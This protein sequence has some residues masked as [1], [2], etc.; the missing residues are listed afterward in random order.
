MK[1]S[2]MQLSVYTRDKIQTLYLTKQTTQQLSTLIAKKSYTV[3]VEM[4]GGELL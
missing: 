2:A 3:V 4:R 1:T